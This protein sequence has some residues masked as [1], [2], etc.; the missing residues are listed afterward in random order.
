MV[1]YGGGVGWVKCGRGCAKVGA[2][3]W[4]RAGDGALRW[5]RRHVQTCIM[6]RGGGCESTYK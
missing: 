2:W 4:L 1:R 3:V 6:V 5:G